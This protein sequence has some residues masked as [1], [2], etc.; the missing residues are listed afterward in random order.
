MVTDSWRH[1]TIKM[2]QYYL[3]LKTVSV[4]LYDRQYTRLSSKSIITAEVERFN[5]LLFGELLLHAV[6]L[7][8]IV[9]PRTSR[10]ATCND[11]MPNVDR[12]LSWSQASAER[13]AVR[14]NTCLTIILRFLMHCWTFVCMIQMEKQKMLPLNHRCP[15]P[16]KHAPRRDD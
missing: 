2:G 16:L 8:P 13:S 7:I 11:S 15:H 5:T 10:F 12:F 4:R 9:L 3:S 6:F 14:R 1:K